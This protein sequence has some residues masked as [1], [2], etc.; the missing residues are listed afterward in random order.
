M[1]ALLELRG[2]SKAYPGE[3]PVVALDGVDLA[4]EAGERVALV[5]A[6]GSGKTTLLHLLGTLE[7]PT[8]GVVAVFGDNVAAL[9]D[10]DLSGIRAP[11]ESGSS[12]SSSS[13][14]NT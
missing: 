13:C 9:R 12:S 8:G 7:R 11:T 10:R 1:S 2:V 6:S 5:G 14:W 3:V 4:V